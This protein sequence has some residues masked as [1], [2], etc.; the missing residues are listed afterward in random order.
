[1]TCRRCE[2]GA[3]IMVKYG[4]DDFKVVL[5]NI[6]VL[7]NFTAYLY[8]V[9][10]FVVLFYDEP[11]GTLFL[12]LALAMLHFVL[13]KLLS[14]KHKSVGNYRH[15]ILTVGIFW[16][17]F[18]FI[19][20]LPFVVVENMNF[21]D[22][23]F[24]SVSATTTTGMTLVAY[25]EF[26][27]Y[28]SIFWRAFIGWVGGVGLILL[29]LLGVFLTYNRFRELAGAE[30]HSET[31]KSN[32]KI[33]VSYIWII[34]IIMTVLG[35]IALRIAGLPLF[36]SII[37][38][39]TTLSSTSTDMSSTGIL[40]YQSIPV[41]IITMILT[42]IGSISFISHYYFFKQRKYNSYFKDPEAIFLVS[43]ILFVFVTT[44]LKYQKLVP[45]DVLYH[46]FAAVGGLSYYSSQTLVALP[47]LFKGLIIFMMFIGGST[48]SSSGGIKIMR[49][50]L[51]I[52]LIGWKIKESML[53]Q[54]AYFPRKYRDETVSDYALKEIVEYVLIYI[55]ILI[56]GTV[57]LTSYGFNFSDSLFEV[58]SAQGGI[59][60]STGIVS[61]TLPIIPKLMI[62]LNM[63]IGRL[64]LI[65]IFA[66]FGMIFSYRYKER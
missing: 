52:K 33:T 27:S 12:Y 48:A 44:I 59:G 5:N 6:S 47:E 37:Y 24:E 38:S 55:L 14:F 34:Y 46:S 60:L 40:G 29:A 19:S 25:P 45:L 28:S 1:M 53:P 7:L 31:L 9:P 49:F 23:Y 2:Y 43:M 30:G 32:I 64:E 57:V 63:L 66:I 4:F 56:A 39:F 21:I 15:A 36:D 20:C 16:V 50:L 13:S 8:L 58:V 35:L 61:I 42:L 22:A 17:L 62:I 26:W 41:L 54:S 18:N 65:P 10:A 51:L 11:A 3:D